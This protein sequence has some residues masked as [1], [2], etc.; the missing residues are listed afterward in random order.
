MHCALITNRKELK[1]GENKTEKEDREKEGGV[2]I[3]TR[4]RAMQRES[5]RGTEI[6]RE[7]GREI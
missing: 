4:E 5:Q 6:D 3:E 7:R 1:G 2:V